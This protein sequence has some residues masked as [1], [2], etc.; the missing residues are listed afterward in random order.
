VQVALLLG[1]IGSGVLL[2]LLAS[3]HCV[4]MCGPIA[5]YACTRR[6]TETRGVSSLV[7]YQSARA[8]GYTVSGALAG[9]L[10]A[11]AL[12][13]LSQPWARATVSFAMA[14]VLLLAAYRLGAAWWRGTGRTTR[15]VP[16]RVPS[17]APHHVQG[18]WQSLRLR[19]TPV[20]VGAATTLLPCG[21]LWAALIVAAG[22]AS[23]VSGATIMLGFAVGSGTGLALA[24]WYAARLQRETRRFA[25]VLAV[26]CL[27]GA[28]LVMGRPVKDFLAKSEVPTCCE[29]GAK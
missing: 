23:A 13:Q 6:G 10:G 1:W 8:A 12:G 28:V 24:G 9:Y 27:V 19:M 26:L 4:A 3:P 20:I 15:L 11:R 22:S 21:V 25:P 2:G 5:A 18:R 14:A 7:G 16:L 29:M 17:Q